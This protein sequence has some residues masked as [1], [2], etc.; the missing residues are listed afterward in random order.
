MLLRV[1][2]HLR[3]ILVRPLA[4]HHCTLCFFGERAAGSAAGNIPGNGCCDG[5]GAFW[6]TSYS[7]QSCTQD[8]T[9]GGSGCRNNT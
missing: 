7:T 5:N 6:N 1:R 2:L 9:R 3:A 4:A 8:T